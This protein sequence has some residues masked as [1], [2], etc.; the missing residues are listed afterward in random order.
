MLIEESVNIC[1]F[2]FSNYAVIKIL[3]FCQTLVFCVCM[4][5]CVCVCMCVFVVVVVVKETLQL[6]KD[7]KSTI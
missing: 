6:N 3:L 2:L 7:W 5:V 1:L 4:Y